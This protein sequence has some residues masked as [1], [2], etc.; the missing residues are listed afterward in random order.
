MDIV[1]W[2]GNLSLVISE[3]TGKRLSSK[4]ISNIRTCL[5]AILEAANEWEVTEQNVMR[6]VKVPKVETK[7]AP[8]IEDKDLP[9]IMEELKKHES[10]T[11]FFLLFYTG[12][13]PSE[14]VGLKYKDYGTVDI[15]DGKKSKAFFVQRTSNED[16]PKTE[17]GRRTVILPPMV[18]SVLDEYIK[19]KSERNLVSLFA[20]KNDIIFTWQKPTKYGEPFS[21]LYIS[22]KFKKTIRKLGLDDSYYLYSFR[23]THATNLLKKGV[24]A[25]IVS[26]RLGHRDIKITLNTYSHVV[27]ALQAKV[28]TDNLLD[29]NVF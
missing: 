16:N 25:K 27:P 21:A 17:S 10:Y 28:I 4:Y 26:E 12:C 3:R 5:F 23:H 11:I 24:H 8:I 22:R 6:K 15:E 9:L 19:K 1:E 7:E 29:L 20:E 13:R 18:A 14:I 2:Q